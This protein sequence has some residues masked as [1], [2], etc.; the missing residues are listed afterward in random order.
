MTPGWAGGPVTEVTWILVVPSHLRGGPQL[1]ALWP[2]PW[3]G[4]LAGQMEK[5]CPGR[6]LALGG[7][8]ECHGRHPVIASPDPKRPQPPTSPRA[9]GTGPPAG[10]T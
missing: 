2:V 4:H 6:S 9:L 8:S 7:V 3:G 1:V 5:W 10:L